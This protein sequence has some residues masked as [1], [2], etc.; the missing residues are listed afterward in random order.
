MIT[1][2]QGTLTEATPLNAVI[3]L[4][5]GL[6]YEVHVP[7]TTAEQLP[8][9][10]Q[11]VKLHTLAIYREDAQTLYGFATQRDRDF[12]RLLIDHVTGVGPKGA[13]GILSRLSVSSLEAAIRGGD[14]ATLAKSPGIGKKTAERLIVELRGKLGD[15]PTALPSDVAGVPVSPKGDSQTQDAVL[16]L[17]ALGY[18]TVDADEAVRRASLALG[19]GAPTEK[20]IKKALSAD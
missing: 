10:G 6:G 12:F 17:V 13:L 11:K 19:A 5:N 8:P 3:E 16:A 14:L 20:I 9:I 1:T 7:L 15:G 4:P 2:I 18:R